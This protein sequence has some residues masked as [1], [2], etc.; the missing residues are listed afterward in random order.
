[1]RRQVHCLI[2][3]VLLLAALSILC[4]VSAVAAVT[5]IP[6]ENE[7]LLSAVSGGADPVEEETDTSLGLCVVYG[8]LTVFAIFFA[9][10]Y[11]RRRRMKKQRK[12]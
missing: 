3:A 1:M 2:A 4:A 7:L 9:A 6:G 12:K 11:P 10:F 5:A 8:L